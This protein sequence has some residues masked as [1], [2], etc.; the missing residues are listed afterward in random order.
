ML[1][2]FEELK[3]PHLK[4]I[5][6]EEFTLRVGRFDVYLHHT[7]LLKIYWMDLQ[8]ICLQITR[9]VAST[10]VRAVISLG[11]GTRDGIPKVISS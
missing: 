5:I 11:A 1:G 10:K 2:V 9:Q 6:I 3:K 7:H 8:Y 4:R